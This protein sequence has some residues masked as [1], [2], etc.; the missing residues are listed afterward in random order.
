MLS[1]QLI[2]YDKNKASDME[3]LHNISKATETQGKDDTEQTLNSKEVL[4]LLNMLCI[5]AEQ[6]K[7]C[8]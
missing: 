4:Q 3:Y 2:L 5:F 1:S 6:K 7:E 8:H